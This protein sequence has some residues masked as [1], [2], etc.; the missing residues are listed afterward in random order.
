[1]QQRA[2]GHLVAGTVVTIAL[3][4]GIAWLS[5]NPSW[6]SMAEDHALVR[7]SFT[8]G[9]DRS[10]SCRDRTP[11]ELAALPK[12]MRKAQICDRHRP[13]VTVELD[14]DGVAIVSR[15]L[16][17]SGLSRTG[18]ARV[19]Q[20]VEVPA[21]EHTFTARMR[22]NPATEGFDYESTTQVTLVPGQSFVI[23]FNSEHGEFVFK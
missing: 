10:A 1:M 21:G 7:I 9:G 14:V 16:A 2:I 3:S 22:D 18:P 4:L 5:A 23:E 12:N 6:Q 11:E 19:Y 17:A 20:R 15:E 8:H 13:P